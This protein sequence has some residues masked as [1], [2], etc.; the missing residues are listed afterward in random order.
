MK[1][2]LVSSALVL[3]AGSA[4][5]QTNTTSATAASFFWGQKATSFMNGTTPTQFWF[6]LDAEQGRSYCVEAGNFEGAY[7]DK[8]PDTQLIVYHNDGVTS[9]TGNDDAVEEPR[10]H[11]L[12]RACWIQTAPS[13]LVKA[14]LFPRDSTI[15]ALTLRFVDTTLFCNWFFIAGDYNAFSLIRNTAKFPMAPVV[16]TWRG[17]DG[18]VLAT[19]QIF[20][21]PNGTAILNARDFV[22]PGVAS[23]GSIEIAH[24]GSPEQI[25]ASTTTLSGTTGLSFDAV[26]GQRKTW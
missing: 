9:I 18:A 24:G 22:D 12:S 21:L 7:G 1:R 4:L 20:L 14:K 25:Q 19:K 15:T 6:L 11:F 3:L 26:F 10:G 2:L 13:E 5:A 23:N 8:N 16:V 17:L